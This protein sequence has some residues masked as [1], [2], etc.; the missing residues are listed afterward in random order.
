MCACPVNRALP[1]L[2]DGP[3]GLCLERPHL[4]PAHHGRLL[5]PTF[6][7]SCTPAGGP[8]ASWA[9]HSWGPSK[10]P[11]KVIK[12]PRAAHGRT[13]SLAILFPRLL[14][15]PLPP[16]LPYPF[17]SRIVSQETRVLLSPATLCIGH[18]TALALPDSLFSSSFPDQDPRGKSS[19]R[20]AADCSAPAQASY[21]SRCSHLLSP[22]PAPPTSSRC[23]FDSH[24]YLGIILIGF[25]S[26]KQEL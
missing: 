22:P 2:A 20:P 17:L 18:S 19:H 5:R 26:F 16:L 10:R 12:P 15:D 8:L 25:V 14:F 4:F 9:L 7:R 3:A 11:A 13:L 21:I 6:A 1:G 23:L 24:R